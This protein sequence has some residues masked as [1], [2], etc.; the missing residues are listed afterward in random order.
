MKSILVIFA[1]PNLQQSVVNKALLSGAA[2][3]DGVTVHDLYQTYPDGVIDI[4]AEQ[5]RLADVDVIVFQ[6][7]FY[8]YSAPSLLKEWLDLVL[9][10]NYAYGPKGDALKDKHWLSVITTGG[11]KQAYCET[12]HNRFTMRELLTPFDQTA[13]LCQ[14]VFLP[15]FVIHSARAVSHSPASLTQH[16]A[17]YQ[18]VL[19]ELVQGKLDVPE[20]VKL[21]NDKWERV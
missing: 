21:M 4:E 6:H 1:H 15:P 2:Q 5:K 12:G 3:I 16:V 20:G 14:M 19:C 8:W 7:P 13:H 18:Q 9:Q 10:F 11:S 17:N